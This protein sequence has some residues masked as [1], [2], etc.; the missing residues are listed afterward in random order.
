MP[1]G[2]SSPMASLLCSSPARVVWQTHGNDKACH[3]RR[4]G[5]HALAGKF[6]RGQD[7]RL[8]PSPRLAAVLLLVAAM[9]LTGANVAFGKAIAAEIPVYAFV[10]FRFAVA[11]AALAVMVR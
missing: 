11:S 7:G 2:D 1:S 8:P 6:G 9:T 10:L 5:A 3:P 4:R